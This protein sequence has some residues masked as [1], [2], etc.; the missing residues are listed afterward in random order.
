MKFL[1]AIIVIFMFFML[2]LAKNETESSIEKSP[3]NSTDLDILQADGA[4]VPPVTSL[5]SSLNPLTTEP[6][7]APLLPTSQSSESC[8]CDLHPFLCDINCCC[9]TGCSVQER[10][11]FSKCSSPRKKHA[12]SKGA[13]FSPMILYSSS[14]S[15]SLYTPLSSQ[16]L[17]IARDNTAKLDYRKN[18]SVFSSLT[19]VKKIIPRHDYG[20]TSSLDEGQSPKSFGSLV[21]RKNLKSGDS[22]FQVIETDSSD[23]Y[24]LHPWKIPYALFSMDGVCDSFREVKFLEPSSTSCLRYIRSLIEDCNSFLNSRTFDKK[25]IA[26]IHISNMMSR[27]KHAQSESDTNGNKDVSKSS[28]V[29]FR[30]N[31]KSTDRCLSSDECV[32][33]RESSSIDTTYVSEGKGK[34][35]CLNAIRGVNY[36]VLYNAQEGNIIGI[37][38]Q[39]QRINLTGSRGYLR[40]FFQIQFTPITLPVNDSSSNDITV[41][42]TPTVSLSGNPGYLF[43]KPLIASNVHLDKP[44]NDTNGDFDNREHLETPILAASSGKCP[45][46]DSVSSVKMEAILFGVNTRSGCLFNVMSM[47]IHE[48][49]RVCQTIQ[50]NI[51]FM[52]HQPQHLT[53]IAVFGNSNKN[54]TSQWIPIMNDKEV[55]QVRDHSQTPSVDVSGKCPLLITG[56]SYEIYY[57]NVGRVDEA[58]AKILG[59]VKKYATAT[60]V[61]VSRIG[62]KSNEMSLES[63]RDLIEVSSSVSFFDITQST[64][65]KYAPSPVLRLQL[66]ADFFYPF[67]VNSAKELRASFILFILSLLVISV[68]SSEQRT[69]KF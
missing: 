46:G 9:D 44:E 29:E 60:A 26:S 61:D 48:L 34:Q 27:R 43:Q 33:I 52:L 17:C 31:M 30:S 47:P 38:V 59:V 54:D 18:R 19:E 22:L 20:W 25:F 32:L 69:V 58:Q 49:T 2:T 6:P 3:N 51:L 1:T 67:F 8:S 62:T 24:S 68:F 28:L 57:A 39:F 23:S 4:D 15:D 53:H 55:M 16:L 66:P 14:S 64:R 11:L 35:S 65:S 36:N 10:R 40:Q 21:P 50:G 63:V 42:L 37:D 41:E 5:P 13:C 12:E 7:S 56:F 45:L